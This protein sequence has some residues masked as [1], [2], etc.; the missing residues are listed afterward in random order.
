MF[1]IYYI[2]LLA[3]KLVIKLFRERPLELTCSRSGGALPLGAMIVFGPA[4][5]PLS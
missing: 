3:S 4:P 2:I 1:R 5:A